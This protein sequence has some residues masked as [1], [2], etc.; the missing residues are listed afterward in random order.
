MK[1]QDLSDKQILELFESAPLEDLNLLHK[2]YK[3]YK[4]IILALVEAY[5]GYAYQKDLY[6]VYKAFYAPQTLSYGSFS[7]ILNEMEKANLLGSTNGNPKVVFMKQKSYELIGKNQTTIH[8]S[9][10]NNRSMKKAKMLTKMHLQLDKFFKGNYRPTML[11]RSVSNSSI[12]CVNAT[13]VE[14]HFLLCLK[15]KQKSEDLKAEIAEYLGKIN[16]FVEKKRV[17]FYLVTDEEA[18]KY[19]TAL[20]KLKDA[21]NLQYHFATQQLT[22]KNLIIEI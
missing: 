8:H 12:Y 19:N 16:G 7:R 9:R 21:S 2:F 3:V 6:E 14:H 4:P 13:N 17:H 5:S 10:I 22:V 20:A 1:F 11:V 15:D 18:K